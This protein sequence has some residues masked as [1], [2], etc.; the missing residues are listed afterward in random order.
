MCSW[1]PRAS[2]EWKAACTY[3]IEQYPGK[4]RKRPGKSGKKVPGWEAVR[5]SFDGCQIPDAVARLKDA[6]QWKVAAE[7]LMAAKMWDN[8]IFVGNPIAGNVLA[9]LAKVP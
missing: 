4:P 2:G 8:G 3:A 9:E 7:R 5:N 1:D 6:D